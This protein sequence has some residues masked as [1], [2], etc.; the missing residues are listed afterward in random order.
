MTT[1]NPNNQPNPAPLSQEQLAAIEDRMV[2]YERGVFR[3]S[4]Y[5]DIAALLQ[6]VERL[7]ES[8]A[9]HEKTARASAAQAGEMLSELVRLREENAELRT[10]PY[11][12]PSEWP[13]E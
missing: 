11:L 3:G 1:T 12:L 7:R 10:R 4:T 9:L 8:V 5:D 13:M 2:L 6:E